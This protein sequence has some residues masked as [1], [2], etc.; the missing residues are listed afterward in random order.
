M[1]LLSLFHPT[2]LWSNL[3]FRWKRKLARKRVFPVL[4]FPEGSL[5]LERLRVLAKISSRSKNSPSIPVFLYANSVSRSSDF[6]SSEGFPKGEKILPIFVD[7]GSLSKDEQGREFGE[8]V[9]YLLEKLGDRFAGL[10][11]LETGKPQAGIQRSGNRTWL[12]HH[13]ALVVEI[14][15]NTFKVLKKDLPEVRGEEDSVSWIPSGLLENN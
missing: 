15:G 4:I 3:L 14:A 1:L 7:F 9:T 11:F 6:L 10:C 13:S 5:S 12:Y 8:Q 2:L